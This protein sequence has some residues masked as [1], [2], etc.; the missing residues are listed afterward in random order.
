MY[1]DACMRECIRALQPGFER[2]QLEFLGM[3][4]LDFG[5]K[6]VTRNT[7]RECIWALQPGFEHVQHVFLGIYLLDFGRKLVTRNTNRGGRVLLSNF[8]IAGLL[9]LLSWSR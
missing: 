9:S 5:R 3:S 2:V 1:V 7:M 6:L 8:P 4:L